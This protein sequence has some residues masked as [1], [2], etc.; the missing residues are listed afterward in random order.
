M[1]ITS[2]GS[3][4]PKKA[5]AAPATPPKRAPNT[6]EKLTTFGPGR[7]CASANASL[8]SC[9]FIQRFCST[10][11][12][13]AQGSAAPKPDSATLTKEMNSSAR[14]GAAGLLWPA[15][16]P[17]ADV[18][19]SDM[20]RAI[21]KRMHRLQWGCCLSLRAPCVWLLRA[22]ASLRLILRSIARAMRLEGWGGP[23]V[24]L[25]FETRCCAAL[26]T[27]RDSFCRSRVGVD[28]HPET[29][30]DFVFFVF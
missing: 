11:M 16:E 6:T 30:C 18:M 14:P 8:N 15:P 2:G 21:A 3:I 20:N 24:A 19:E 7:N 12:R 10:I 23:D 25:W 22:L 26:L 17:G 5:A 4:R 1:T 29:I 9:V 27:M 13:R 28:G